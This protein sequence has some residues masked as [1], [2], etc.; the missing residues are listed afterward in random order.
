MRPFSSTEEM[1]EAMVA[2]WN[3][4]VNPKDTVYH[5]GDVVIA[6]KNL[7]TLKRLNGKKRLIRGNHDMFKDN[8]YYEAGFEK[9]LGVRVFVDQWIMSHIPL[10]PDSIGPRFKIN[11]HGHLHTN[12]VRKPRGFNVRTGEMLYSDTPDPLYMSVCVEKINYT[13]ISFDD[14]QLKIQDMWD[15]QGYVYKRRSVVGPS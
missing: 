11:V 2:N 14:L 8:D 13:P 4:V 15:A 12:Y 9:I 10:H 6:R 5:C 1:D 3:R 7:Q